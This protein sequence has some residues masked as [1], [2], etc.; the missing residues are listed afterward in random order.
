MGYYVGQILAE[1]GRRRAL[2]WRA[3]LVPVLLH[4]AY[5][6]PLM[7]ARAGGLHGLL[8]VFALPV[9]WLAWHTARRLGR[10]VRDAQG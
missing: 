4:G 8:G 5:D 1:P 7:A 10:R 6:F 3:W 2:L 9:L